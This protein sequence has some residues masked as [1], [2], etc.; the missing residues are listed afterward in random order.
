MIKLIER[1]VLEEDDRADNQEDISIITPEYVAP[2]HFD[3][4]SIL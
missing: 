3:I 4:F 1:T 2:K